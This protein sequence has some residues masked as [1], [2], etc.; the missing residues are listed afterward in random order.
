MKR[1]KNE[2]VWGFAEVTVGYSASFE[3]EIKANMNEF[4]REQ[5][6]DG[7]GDYVG[8]DEMITFC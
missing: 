7:W 3:N 5:L 2:L 8:E 6:K 1:Y 4:L